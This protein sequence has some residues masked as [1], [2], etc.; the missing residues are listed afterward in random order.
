MCLNENI[1]TQIRQCVCWISKDRLANVHTH[2]YP[3]FFCICFQ[4]G[5]Y[6]VLIEFVVQRELHGEEAESGGKG[7]KFHNEISI[8]R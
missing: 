7:I 2:T 8:H 1:W 6:G 4:D 5:K 3:T